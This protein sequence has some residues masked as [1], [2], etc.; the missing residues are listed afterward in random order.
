MC[1]IAWQLGILIKNSAKQPWCFL[2][3]CC[4]LFLL[5]NLFKLRRENI[6]TNRAPIRWGPWTWWRNQG[7]PKQTQIC[8]NVHQYKLENE[9]PNT[10]RAT[11]H[12]SNSRT[13]NTMLPSRRLPTA[14][15]RSP[16]HKEY[17]VGA[18]QLDIS[19]KRRSQNIHWFQE[20]EW[21]V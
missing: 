18:C 16:R 19:G 11:L 20:N 3:S 9:N 17:E 7:P 1:G 14:R 6:Y 5:L 15:M 2:V 8:M 13:T 10:A 21:K 4:S 12:T